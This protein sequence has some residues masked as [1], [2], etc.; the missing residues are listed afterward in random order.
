VNKNTGSSMKKWIFLAFFAGIII[1]GAYM[2]FLRPVEV[3]ATRVTIG[4]VKESVQGPG[5]VRAKIP[6]E[7]STKI[8]G[9]ITSLLVDQG[10]NVKKGQLIATLDDTDSLAK[11]SSSKKAVAVAENDLETARAGLEKARADLALAESNYRRDHEVF[12]AGYISPAAM[13]ATDAALQAAESNAKAAE[14]V[15]SSRIAAVEK[16]KEDMHYAEAMLSYTRIYALTDGVITQRDREVGDTVSPGVPIFDMVDPMTI[17]AMARIDETVVGNVEMNQPALIRLRSGGE[18]KG[19]V[20]RIERQSNSVTRE[21][22]VDVAF[23]DVPQRFAIDQEADVTIFI[24]EARGLVIP[25][26][27]VVSNQKGEHGV[28]LVKDGRARF[29]PVQTGATDGR[30][31]IVVKGLEGGEMVI[32]EPLVTPGKRVRIQNRET[33]V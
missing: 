24:S 23:D 3:K 15:I 2:L 16:A 1:F 4:R 31:T 5:L 6:V 26:A 7:V 14:T 32:T 28:M 9:V 22:E 20:A 27:A 12:K 29:Q 17:W 8:T 18:F 11:L 13:D 19:Y 21:L 25:A 33:G 30:R 10:D